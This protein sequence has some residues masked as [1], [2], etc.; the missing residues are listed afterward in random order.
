MT[1]GMSKPRLCLTLGV[2]DPLDDPNSS[3]SSASAFAS[4]TAPPA[5]CVASGTAFSRGAGRPGTQK[6]GSAIVET[7]GVGVAVGGGGGARPPSRGACPDTP[8]RSRRAGTRPK[9]SVMTTGEAVAVAVVAVVAVASCSTGGP[10]WWAGGVG[11]AV[12]DATE[13]RVVRVV[14]GVAGGVMPGLALGT[15]PAA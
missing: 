15:R 4:V 12:A 3:F 5:A 6:G 9:R 13:G 14:V 7:V 2:I 11:P 1:H 8:N 10:A